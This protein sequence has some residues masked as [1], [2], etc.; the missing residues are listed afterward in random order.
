MRNPGLV[1]LFIAVDKVVVPVLLAGEES[2]PRR[3]A[4]G[5]VVEGTEH[6]QAAGVAGGLHHVEP[7]QG[8]GDTH[9]GEH[10]DAAVVG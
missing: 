7:G 8:T 2:A 5:A 4:G 3:D 6:L 9:G 10:A 1:I